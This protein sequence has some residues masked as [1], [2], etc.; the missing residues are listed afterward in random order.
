MQYEEFLEMVK[1]RRTIRAIK[2]DPIPD[3][4]VTKLLEA[5]RWAPTGFN[6]QPAEFLVVREAELRASIKKIVDDY[7]NRTSLPWKPHE[8]SGRAPLGPSKHM[9]D[10]IAHRLL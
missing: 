2:P 4:M 8:S 1:N 3:E 7:K 5:G 9:G 10:G 6:M